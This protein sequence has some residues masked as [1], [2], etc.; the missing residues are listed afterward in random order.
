VRFTYPNSK[1]L[2][3]TK[4]HIVHSNADEMLMYKVPSVK[5]SSLCAKTIQTLPK[6]EMP[7]SRCSPRF[8]AV[9]DRVQGLPVFL[10]AHSVNKTISPRSKGSLASILNTAYYADFAHSL[11]LDE[12]SMSLRPRNLIVPN[13][14]N[15]G[16]FFLA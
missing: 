5:P 13:V 10:R 6:I 8:T 11:H 12:P 14:F 16:S 3:M 1:G 7:S 4:L 9:I 2:R 15:S